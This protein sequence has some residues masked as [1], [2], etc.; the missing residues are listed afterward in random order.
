[1]KRDLSERFLSGEVVYEGRLLHVRRDVVSLP[2]GKEA[3]REYIRHPGAVAVIPLFE[4][5][6]ILLERQFRYPNARDF[7]EIPAGKIDPGE[8]RLETARRELL[9]ETGYAAN[10]LI[11]LGAIHVAVSYTDEAVEIYV[12]RGLTQSA[13]V[14]KLDEEE[15]LETFKVPF[16]Q[17]LAMVRDGRIT[18][19]K[20]VAG[21]YWLKDFID[22]GR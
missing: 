18:D 9:E 5:G 17:A 15:F 6:S 14:A 3:S 12:A 13:G 8:S 20:S 2:N 7:I 21:L 22:A 11:R 19:A 4:D 1:M 10:E 16:D